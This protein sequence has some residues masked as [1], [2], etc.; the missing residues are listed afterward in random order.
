MLTLVD[1]LEK[2]KQEDEIS[3]LEL[4][5][6]TSEDLLDRFVD[7]VEDK[8]DELVLEYTDDEEDQD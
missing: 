6:L 1:L 2:L 5:G 4:L 8:Y 3:L 7:I